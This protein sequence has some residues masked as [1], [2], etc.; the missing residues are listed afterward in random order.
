MVRAGHD[1]VLP[2]ES[3]HGAGRGDAAFEQAKLWI[4]EKG[5]AGAGITLLKKLSNAGRSGAKELLAA[6]FYKG[7]GVDE[8]R[9]AAVSLMEESA[10][11][12]SPSACGKLGAFYEAG[13]NGTPDMQNAL[14][15]YQRGARLGSK[16]A[17]RR[18][19]QLCLEGEKI[20]RDFPRGLA[21]C[22]RG[23]LTGDE[24][25]AALFHGLGAKDAEALSRCYGYPKPARRG[26]K[27]FHTPAP[28][29]QVFERARRA[30][31]KDGWFRYS[32]D[33][34]AAAD[35]GVAEAREIL[36]KLYMTG[37]GAKKNLFQANLWYAKAAEQ[38]SPSAPQRMAWWFDSGVR[39]FHNEWLARVYARFAEE[40]GGKEYAA[41]WNL[42]APEGAEGEKRRA[43]PQ[44]ADYLFNAGTAYAD[45]DEERAF[46]YFL[47]AA[48][49]G[50]VKGQL[51]TGY[52]YHTGRGTARNMAQA[53]YW[54]R[55][56]AEQ[57]NA[58][59]MY[60]LGIFYAN[61]RGAAQ[62]DEEAFRWYE[63][64]AQAGHADA[65]LKTGYWYEVGRGAAKDQEKAVY[66]YRKAAE[67]GSAAGMCNLG[68]MYLW[69]KGAEKSPE[70]AVKWYQKAVE[71]G[72]ARGKFLS[73]KCLLDGTGIAA[74]RE[75][76]IELL[77]AAAQ[78]DLKSEQEFLEKLG[79]G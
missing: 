5:T 24:G 18:L 39:G 65:R 31:K 41:Y 69:G 1:R 23:I 53:V 73:A 66:W 40:R 28:G 78:Q 61:G 2:G 77:R 27:L 72:Y 14:Q 22:V 50:H 48:K 52:R 6:C 17:L 25:C 75:A 63:R 76:A 34:Q 26:L 8:N 37:A 42:G 49:A 12:A 32:E 16:E 64:A 21:C 62:N 46:S 11:M 4:Q 74:D 59:A 79:E 15:W 56:A 70:T 13:V 10:R 54:Y 47:S 20:E 7:I 68:N 67:Q 33:L 36:A 38:G 57:G 45:E 43:D 29:E 60:N 19:A 58:Q 9:A 55:K 44:D 30:A 51:E 71:N 35:G 3:R